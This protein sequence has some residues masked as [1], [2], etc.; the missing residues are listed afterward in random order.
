M[1]KQG[2]IKAVTLDAD[3][4]EPCTR[5]GGCPNT[6]RFFKILN[7]SYIL[8]I[9]ENKFMKNY[10]FPSQENY[11]CPPQFGILILSLDA[12]K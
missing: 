11:I 12:K 1:V 8:N 2:Y 10:I 9:L 6:P 7:N 5:R 4:A 3:T